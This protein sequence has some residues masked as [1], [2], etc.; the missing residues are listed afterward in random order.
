ML[1]QTRQ[2]PASGHHVMGTVPQPSHWMRA[3]TLLILLE[4]VIQKH[5]SRRSVTD[6]VLLGQTGRT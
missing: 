5:Y 6:Q 2:D 3:R 4:L 1:V